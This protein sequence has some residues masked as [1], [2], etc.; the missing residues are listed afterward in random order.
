MSK[1]AIIRR[2][3]EGESVVVVS[4]K[5]HK[6]YGI[7]RKAVKV[8][9]N[10]VKF[11]DGSWL[12]FSDLDRETLNGFKLKSKRYIAMPTPVEGDTIVYEWGKKKLKDVV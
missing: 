5:G 3:S 10:A 2:L 11:E 12:Y 6:G 1:A 7:E 4:P 9:T 8:Q